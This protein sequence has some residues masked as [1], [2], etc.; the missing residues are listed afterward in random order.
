[1]NC[2]FIDLSELLAKLRAITKLKNTMRYQ[3]RL[4]KTKSGTLWNLV[5]TPHTI[6]N[7]AKLWLVSGSPLKKPIPYVLNEADKSHSSNIS[8]HSW[9]FQG[10]CLVL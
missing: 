6:I 1:M 8:E 10:A 7:H 2:R 4:S 9:P 5:R 3:E